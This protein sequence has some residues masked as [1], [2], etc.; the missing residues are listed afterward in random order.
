[1]SDITITLAPNSKVSEEA[2]S[3]VV[4]GC[5]KAISALV[6]KARYVRSIN[7]HFARF[8]NTL[9]PVFRMCFTSYNTTE[10]WTQTDF[11]CFG[12]AT[13]PCTVESLSKHL[14]S[15]FFRVLPHTLQNEISKTN[16]CL[17]SMTEALGNIEQQ[18]VICAS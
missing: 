16:A 1:M 10:F 15:E 4:F 13:F 8:N 12:D 5:A 6:D 17:A 11:R 14:V 9:G 7:V 2:L 3:I 18:S